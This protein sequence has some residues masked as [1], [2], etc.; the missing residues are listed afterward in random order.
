[1]C[2]DLD[3]QDSDSAFEPLNHFT[4]GDGVIA[5]QYRKKGELAWKT[6]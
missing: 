5:M 4:D 1:V 3:D 2:K 6:L